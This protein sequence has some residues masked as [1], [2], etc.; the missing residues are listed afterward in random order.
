MTAPTP[1]RPR[2]RYSEMMLANS[3]PFSPAGPMQATRKSLPRLALIARWV[4]RVSVP[5]RAA[6]GCRV[7]TSSS[8][9]SMRG[10]AAR[11]RTMIM[12]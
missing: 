5:Q 4:A 2:A 8:I 1:P 12:S 6:A 9:T 3:T 7:T 11:P 10:S